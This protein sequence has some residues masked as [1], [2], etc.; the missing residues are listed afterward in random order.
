MRSLILLWL[1]LFCAQ[2]LSAEEMYL[3]YCEGEITNNTVSI[4]GTNKTIECAICLPASNVAG[5][6]G[7]N[8][9]RIKVGVNPDCPKLPSYV[10]AWVRSDVNGANLV[11]KK[12]AV[13]KG[14][15]DIALDAPLSI[16]EGVD[17]WIGYSYPQASTKLKVIAFGGKPVEGYSYWSKNN[18]MTGWTDKS[19]NAVGAL[20]VEAVVEGDNLPQHDLLLK[21]C[22][23][24]RRNN[25]LGLPLSV[26][27]LL[28]NNAVRTAEGFDVA[29]MFNDN[30]ATAGIVSLTQHVAYRE[31]SKF[32]ITIPTD[33]LSLGVNTLRLEV[34]WRGGVVDDYVADNIAT[35]SFNIFDTGYP[36][37]AMLEEFTTE[38]CGW[39]PMG[40]SYINQ[41][42][43]DTGLRNS[44]VWVCHHAG[45]GTDFLTVTE[46]N[47]YTAMF[48]TQGTFA[49][50]MMVNREL[51][52]KYSSQGVVG[53]ATMEPAYTADWLS[54]SVEVPANVFVQILSASINEG[55][56]TIRVRVEKSDAF[57][58]QAPRP[59]I[60][61]W[62]TENHIPM[63][64]QADNAGLKTGFHEHA[65]RRVLTATWGND[66][67]W[68]GNAY[69][70]EFTC[71]VGNGWVAE[72]LQAVAFVSN[73]TATSIYQREIFNAAET[74]ITNGE[75]GISHISADVPAAET[76]YSVDGR[77]SDGRGRGIIVRRTVSS[78]GVVRTEKV[79]NNR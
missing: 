45:F 63:R 52:S 78:D 54:E 46:S 59:R 42:L 76:M 61:V 22:S 10:T 36:R 57:D 66:I 53:G 16:P 64:N 1:S 38:Q 12:V 7:Q 34:R 26:T 25:K 55:K 65:L 40:I 29:Y 41:A 8:I 4:T 15:N 62:V 2:L 20:C 48:G 32:A 28:R 44:V 67:T 70:E 68:D 13:D 27:G 71:N 9:T 14:W 39:C 31:E 43:D 5:L 33:E 72:N 51:H 37:T 6:V 73:Y 24:S 47:T 18:S 50:A 58:S 75:Q 19:T 17:L 21:T 3:G 74:A 35:L 69:E 77:L 49:P 23:V 79:I 11:E 60:N 56:I 30:D